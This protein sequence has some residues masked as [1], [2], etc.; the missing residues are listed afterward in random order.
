ME[1]TDKCCLGRR[2]GRRRVWEWLLSY[3]VG[4]VVSKE[5]VQDLRLLVVEAGKFTLIETGTE[6]F[7]MMPRHQDMR[8]TGTCKRTDT[9]YCGD[10]DRSYS[11]AG[12]RLVH[13]ACKCKTRMVIRSDL[14]HQHSPYPILIE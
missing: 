10:C 11:Q 3:W 5:C 4:C 1:G 6:H 13:F 2:R 14:V 7:H 12:L 8:S 9:K